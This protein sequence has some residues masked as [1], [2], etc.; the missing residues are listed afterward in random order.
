M[1]FIHLLQQDD[2]V[3]LKI[4]FLDIL[5]VVGDEF[6]KRKITEIEIEYGEMA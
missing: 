4:L 3:G 2:L 5:E 6:S 1:L